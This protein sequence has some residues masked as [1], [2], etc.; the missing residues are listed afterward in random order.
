M[1]KYLKNIIFPHFGPIKTTERKQCM[2]AQHSTGELN[3]CVQYNALI[4]SH[5]LSRALVI[6]LS[7]C[8]AVSCSPR[9]QNAW[10][11]S[12]LHDHDVLPWLLSSSS[13]LN[14]CRPRS[15]ICNW[16][17]QIKCKLLG[18][19]HWWLFVPPNPSKLGHHNHNLA[20]LVFGR[21]R[22]LP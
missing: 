1:F 2:R 9:A 6:F 3:D 11:S 15:A 5:T 18:G 20:D 7:R 21:F 16:Y 19:V 4:M 13:I 8:C 10:A 14:C 22:I 17:V 12:S